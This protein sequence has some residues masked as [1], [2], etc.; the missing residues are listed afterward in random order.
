M[1]GRPRGALCGISDRASCRPA[2]VPSRASSVSAWGV[3]WPPFARVSCLFSVVL[4]T[5]RRV[6]GGSP[7][8]ERVRAGHCG[9]ATGLGDTASQAQGVRRRVPRAVTGG[10]AARAPA[11]ALTSRQ[12]GDAWPRASADLR[13]CR[14]HSDTPAVGGPGAAPGRGRGARGG[15]ARSVFESRCPSS[16]RRSAVP[17]GGLALPVARATSHPAGCPGLPDRWSLRVPVRF[18]LV[19]FVPSG[20]VSGPGGAASSRHVVPGPAVS[21]CRGGCRQSPS[22]AEPCAGRGPDGRRRSPARLLLS[23]ESPPRSGCQE[24]RAWLVWLP[25]GRRG[26]TGGGRGCRSSLCSR[27]CVAACVV[28]REP[29]S[30]TLG[31]RCPRAVLGPVAGL[32]GEDQC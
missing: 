32:R 13:V 23:R 22:P 24:D 29:R 15:A 30:R 10:A 16:G 25:G 5:R 11:V 6:T 21:W 7:G 8:G 3:G 27:G 17:W 1:R 9:L 4:Q 18:G 19:S 26:L 14:G 28:D 31:L 20:C 12:V 2:P